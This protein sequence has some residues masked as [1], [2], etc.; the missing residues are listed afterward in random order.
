MC[1]KNTRSKEYKMK[2]TITI[3]LLPSVGKNTR[4]YTY[5][6]LENN[7]LLHTSFEVMGMIEC[8]ADAQ[9]MLAFLAADIE[10][11]PSV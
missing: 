11:A 3:T 1:V 4:G 9:L 2:N 5:Q 10:L 8:L 6:I 7:E